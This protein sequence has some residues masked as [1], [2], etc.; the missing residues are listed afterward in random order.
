MQSLLFNALPTSAPISQCSKRDKALYLAL[1]IKKVL[2]ATLDPEKFDDIHYCGNRR[3]ELSGD[4]LASLFEDLFKRMNTDLKRL[5]HLQLSKR[6]KSSPFDVVKYIRS[7][8]ISDGVDAAF[9]SG[10]WTLKHF[11]SQLSGVTQDLSRLSFIS[12]LGMMNRINTQYQKTRKVFGPRAL[13]S[14]QWGI[15]CPCD[16]PEG[17]NCGIV[18]N[19]AI[20]S[21][22]TMEVKDVSIIS[23]SFSMGVQAMYKFTIW[24]LH[25]KGTALVLFNGLIIGIH[26]LPMHFIS[27]MR[28]LRREDCFV[29]FVSISYADLCI[30]VYSDSGRSCRPL[31]LCYDGVPRMTKV[32]L[33]ILKLGE[34]I[35]NKLIA[36]SPFI[37]IRIYFRFLFMNIF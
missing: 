17:D 12:T 23:I 18:K 30:N 1:M 33:F 10:N 36:E 28:L 9:L 2:I 13:N 35:F 14:S 6:N 21:R 7:T 8:I 20:F 29:R 11:H 3:F 25:K 15:L 22:F 34:I 32:H 37:H 26:I 27:K 16:T 24:E 5:V 4:L 31:I 19:L